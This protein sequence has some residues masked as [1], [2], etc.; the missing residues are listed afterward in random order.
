M[1]SAHRQHCYLSGRRPA[2][3]Q[4]VGVA[5]KQLQRNHALVGKLF[6]G[7]PSGQ[8]FP[9][10]SPAMSMT[11]MQIRKMRVAVDKRSMAV[12]MTVRFS[13]WIF[14]RVTMLVMR[15]MKM[16]MLVLQGVMDMF[17]D[18]PFN[19]MQIKTYPHENGCRRK[20]NAQRF[21]KKNKCQD[22]SDKRRCGKVGSCSC[23]T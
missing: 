23:T 17:M 1:L 11:V 6:R 21:R 20:A 12:A 15:V 18:M 8:K 19:E 16:A 7:G 14:R 5:H 22:C 10:T 4:L 13:S 9:L 3:P 2:V